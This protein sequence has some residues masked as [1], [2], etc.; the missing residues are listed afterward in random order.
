MGH[1]I[2]MDWERNN[3]VKARDKMHDPFT[4]NCVK[5]IGYQFA[6]QKKQISPLELF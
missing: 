4:A 2:A 1:I 5:A 6:F 3:L